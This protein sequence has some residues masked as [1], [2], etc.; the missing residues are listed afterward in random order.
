MARTV[1]LNEPLP[2][3]SPT[4]GAFFIVGMFVTRTPD[5]DIFGVCT[6]VFVVYTRYYN[7]KFFCRWVWGVELEIFYEVKI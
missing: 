3:A 7:V 4:S 6:R 1:L 2:S 5:E